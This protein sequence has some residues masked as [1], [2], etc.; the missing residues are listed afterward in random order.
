MF[1]LCK[2]VDSI[3][4]NLVNGGRI[5]KT[6]THLVNNNYI[7][8]YRLPNAIQIQPGDEIK[9][10]C[11]F[12]SINKKKTTFMGRGTSEEMC[13]GFLEVYPNDNLRS[14][15]CVNWRSLS[16]TKLNSRKEPYPYECKTYDFLNFT[17]PETAPLFQKLKEN[18]KPLSWCLKECKEVVKEVR[19]HPC[20]E[21]DMGKFTRAVAINRFYGDIPLFMS[22]IQSCDLEL[23]EEKLQNQ[24]VKDDGRS[25]S[26]IFH[27]RFY[28]VVSLFLF[29]SFILLC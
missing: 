4:L 10:T 6:T 5:Y 9:T 25:G 14:R 26:S 13:F 1:Y 15:S 22:L 23:L 29:V 3:F 12:K 2:L 24:M 27:L 28:E 8:Y 7:K 20:M 18:C 16:M 11:I 19:K 17:H 21:G